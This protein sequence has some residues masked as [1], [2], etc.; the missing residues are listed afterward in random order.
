MDEKKEKEEKKD[1]CRKKGRG[2]EKEV[3]VDKRTKEQEQNDSN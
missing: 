1:V 3:Y 2:K